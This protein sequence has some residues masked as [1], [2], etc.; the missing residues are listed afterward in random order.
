[1]VA[2]DVAARLHCHTLFHTYTTT[3]TVYYYILSTGPLPRFR[4]LSF[5]HNLFKMPR[6]YVRV[7][8]QRTRKN[9]QTNHFHYIIPCILNYM[10]RISASNV[11]LYDFYYVNDINYQNR[12]KGNDE[13][14]LRAY[15]EAPKHTKNKKKEYSFS[16]IFWLINDFANISKKKKSLTKKSQR[17]R[18]T[19]PARCYLRT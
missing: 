4:T 12:R 8:S 11:C 7:C 9:E 1:M 17:P 10:G 15:K 18:K 3:T 5:G 2:S 6:M 13:V 16:E 19:P 14:C